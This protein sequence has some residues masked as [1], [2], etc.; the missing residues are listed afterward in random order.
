MSFVG[1][2]VLYMYNRSFLSFSHNS[3]KKPFVKVEGEWN[4]VMKK[5]FPNGVSA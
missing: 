2:S 3:D 5:K 1:G 4:G